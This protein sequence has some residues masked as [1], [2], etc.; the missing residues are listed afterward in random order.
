M[1]LVED[2][3]SPRNS[4]IMGR[5]KETLPDSSGAVRRVKLQTKTNILE[6]PVNKLCFIKEVIG[7]V[8]ET[9]PD[10][11][12]AGIIKKKEKGNVKELSWHFLFNFF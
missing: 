6:R 8:K 3:S 9:L 4:W 1:V 11:N 12:G 10:S 2:R 5:V 7:R